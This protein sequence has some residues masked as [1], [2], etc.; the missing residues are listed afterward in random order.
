MSVLVE[1]EI[2]QHQCGNCGIIFGM[3]KTYKQNLVSNDGSYFCPNGCNRQFCAETGNAKLKKEL[4]AKQSELSAARCEVLQERQKREAI[5]KEQLRQKQRAAAG[6]CSCCNR[7]FSNLARHMASKHGA[8]Q[9]VK[10]KT[11]PKGKQ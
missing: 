9:Y 4:E 3:E 2:V 8:G 6:V 11:K 10:S 1:I 5:E 7:T